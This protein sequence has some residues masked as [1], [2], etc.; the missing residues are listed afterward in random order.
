MECTEPRARAELSPELD[1][2]IERAAAR[3]R[4][5][6]YWAAAFRRAE[7]A[8]LAVVVATLITFGTLLLLKWGAGL[9]H[10]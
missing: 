2:Q 8:G 4:R 7:R 1:E 9:M 5:A 10:P 6:Q 3:V